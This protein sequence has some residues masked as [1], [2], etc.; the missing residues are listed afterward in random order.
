MIDT[1]QRAKVATAILGGTLIRIVGAT[2]VAFEKFVAGLNDTSIITLIPGNARNPYTLTKG[3]IATL[4][5]SRGRADD[6]GDEVGDYARR[7][8]HHL[9]YG[10]LS[11][12]NRSG[13][14][15]IMVLPERLSILSNGQFEQENPRPRHGPRTRTASPPMGRGN[16]S[17]FS[18]FVH[19]VE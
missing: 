7:R 1:T 2:H 15:W 12:R 18:L 4:T 3:T 16:L 9:R 13:G 6:A 10:V 17:L 14:E 19:W 5:A 8:R 11:S